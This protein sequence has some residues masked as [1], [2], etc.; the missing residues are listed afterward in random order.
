MAAVSRPWA[1]APPTPTVGSL[2]A[3][4]RIALTP[5]TGTRAKDVAGTIRTDGAASAAK[6]VLDSITDRT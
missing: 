4:L 3:A 2:S 1:S 6:L 5:E